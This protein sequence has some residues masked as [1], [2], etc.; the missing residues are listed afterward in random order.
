MPAHAPHRSD[1]SPD[2]PPSVPGWRH[3]EH[4]ADIGVEGVGASPAEAF[5]QAA[6]ALTAIVC[7]P[8]AVQPRTA[9]DIACE[10]PDLELLLADW[11]NA[12]IYRMATTRML[13][14]QFEVHITSG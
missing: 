7:D 11:L 14:S 6:L 13:F 8:A 12:L 5:S 3:F 9:L 2:R 4:R 10:A 1:P